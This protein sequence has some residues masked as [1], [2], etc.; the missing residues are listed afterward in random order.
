M[1][2]EIFVAQR[3]TVHSLSDQLFERVLDQQRTPAVDETLAEPRQQVHL[4][5]G[6]L[7]QKTSGV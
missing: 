2:V 4:Q 3:Q 1:V 7:Q 5:I 6:L